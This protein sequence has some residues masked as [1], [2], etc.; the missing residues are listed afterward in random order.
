[1]NKGVAR[2]CKLHRKH[3]VIYM[4]GWNW[5]EQRASLLN[6]FIFY[7]SCCQPKRSIDWLMRLGNMRNS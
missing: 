6:Y 7:A 5:N 2:T 4:R 3:C 1:M